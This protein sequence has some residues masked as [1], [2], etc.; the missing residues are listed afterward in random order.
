MVGEI[1]CTSAH[2]VSESGSRRA[3][4]VSGVTMMLLAAVEVKSVAW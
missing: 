3:G 2:G 1:V 4:N